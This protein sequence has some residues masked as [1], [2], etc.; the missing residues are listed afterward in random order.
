MLA[1]LTTTTTVSI[2]KPWGRIR[3]RAAHYERLNQA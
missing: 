2:F 3:R 1:V